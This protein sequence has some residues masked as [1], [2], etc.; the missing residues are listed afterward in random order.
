MLPE[1]YK[2]VILTIGYLLNTEPQVCIKL[3]KVRQ[4]FSVP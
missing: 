3:I 1:K 2:I 4:Y